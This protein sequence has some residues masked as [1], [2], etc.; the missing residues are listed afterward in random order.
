MR[1]FGRKYW[2]GLVKIYTLSS[3]C[4]AGWFKLA[5]TL[6][7]KQ[8]KAKFAHVKSGENKQNFLKRLTPR[9]HYAN[10]STKCEN[11]A[12]KHLCQFMWLYLSKMYRGRLI[13]VE[14]SAFC[15][16]SPLLD[17]QQGRSDTMRFSVFLT[18]TCRN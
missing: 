13:K 6:F 10:S 16:L 3:K 9:K 15:A 12:Y 1:E 4:I 5:I 14:T 18:I 11:G 17:I 8:E 2:F 7:V